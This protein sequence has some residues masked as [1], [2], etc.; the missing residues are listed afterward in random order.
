MKDFDGANHGPW[1][2]TLFTKGELVGWQV[3]RLRDKD[4]IDWEGNREYVGPLFKSEQEARIWLEV[5]EEVL[6]W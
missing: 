2:I 3:Y 5:N 6:P 1:R 4:N